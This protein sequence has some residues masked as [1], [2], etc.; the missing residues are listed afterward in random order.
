MPERML[1]SQWREFGAAS[2][3]LR[4]VRIVSDLLDGGF[5]QG[6]RASLFG[7]AVRQFDDAEELIANARQLAAEQS[8][9]LFKTAMTPDPAMEVIGGDHAGRQRGGEHGP[10]HPSGRVDQAIEQRTCQIGH[11][12][13]E[14]GHAEGFDHFDRPDAA[15]KIEQLRFERGGN[16]QLVRRMDAAHDL[17]P[18]RGLMDRTIGRC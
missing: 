7:F 8:G 12:E 17:P 14:G 6:A 11:A 18:T 1:Q 2:L 13:A 3:R 16:L 10:A 4:L 9:E 15:A 5:A